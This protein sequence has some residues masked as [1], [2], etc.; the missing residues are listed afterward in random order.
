DIYSK[1]SAFA[2]RNT[3]AKA[4]DEAAQSEGLSKRVASNIKVSDFVIE[5]IGPSREIIRWVYE[6]KNGNVSPIFNVDNRYI[7]AKLTD[8]QEKGLMKPDANN[9]PMLE[10]AV[11]AE[12]KAKIL[13]DKYTNVTSLEALA[14]AAGQSVGTADSFNANSTYLPF[15]GPEPKI[16]GYSFYEGFKENTIS[17][18]ITGQDGIFFISLKQR[19]ENPVQENDYAIGQQKMMAEMQLKNTISSG[20]MDV[21]KRKSKIEYNGNLLY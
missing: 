15:L 17:P 4:F 20:V 7:V 13:K 18:A 19:S 11:K 9:R 14:S 16:V 8:V 21:L 3:D 6:A 2:G 12:K 1:A 5:G 10:A